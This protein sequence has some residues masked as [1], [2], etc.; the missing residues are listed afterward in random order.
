MRLQDIGETGLI[1]LLSERIKNK[2]DNIIKGIGD[3]TAVIRIDPS[4]FLLATTDMLV[5]GEHF[6]LKSITGEALGY[7]ALAV[8]LSD[9]AA[10]G[11]RAKHALVAIGLPADL[12][13]EYILEI[14]RG[15]QSLADEFAVSI[16]GG[17]T[18][19]SPAGL[20]INVTVLGVVEPTRVLL[21]SGAKPGDLILV[22][23]SL[24]HSRAGLELVKDNYIE[25]S[26]EERQE[27]LSRHYYPWPRLR[28]IDLL[29]QAG[30]INSLND[31]S[32][33][34]AKDL[35]EITVASGVGA[36]IEANK[37]PVNGLTKKI[38][39]QKG[40]NPLDYVFYGGEDFELVLTAEP[41]TARELLAQAARENIEL[42]VIGKII[43]E[44]G[45]FLQQEGS[46]PSLIAGGWDHFRGREV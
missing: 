2:N 29:V 1:K 23:G 37:V 25:L 30:K 34:L 42:H 14:Y 17:D 46:S 11:G 9:I 16:V 3:D 38:A 12:E 27:A 28:E 40:H 31:I 8:N 43:E 39:L 24:G 35:E 13:V 19:S 15:M 20:V 21:R 22:T 5:E 10:M 33:G 26:A 44:A 18:V 6:L 32:D 36:V 7:K 45:L 4:L 41:N